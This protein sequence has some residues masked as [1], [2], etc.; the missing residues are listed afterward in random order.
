M[1]WLRRRRQG[2]A[3]VL[4]QAL[5]ALLT[6]LLVG[7]LTAQTLAAVA[8]K[9]ERRFM[10]GRKGEVVAWILAGPYATPQSDLEDPTTWQK[11][12]SAD[13]HR[14]RV[15]LGD[16][17]PLLIVPPP[18]GKGVFYCY[19][20][21]RAKYRQDAA[22]M[23]ASLQPFT[24]IAGGRKVKAT[25]SQ[26]AG[27]YRGLL[28]FDA[29]KNSTGILVRLT[30]QAG[31]RVVLVA[32]AKS[33]HARGAEYLR[34]ME[35]SL[36]AWVPSVAKPRSLTLE[37]DPPLPGVGLSR[38]TISWG[39]G[40]E[41]P[42]MGQALTLS[43]TGPQGLD[44][45][46]PVT[47]P[48]HTT[49]RL[50]S[51][52]DF[53]VDLP[54]TDRLGGEAPLVAVLRCGALDL[55]R[56]PV[57]TGVQAGRE[58][59]RLR[60]R[61]G[62]GEK[63]LK[64]DF[65]LSRF[66]LLKADELFQTLKQGNAYRVGSGDLARVLAQVK[67]WTEHYEA[68]GDPLAGRRGRIQG[69][70]I[71]R[72]DGSVQPYELYVPQRATDGPLPLVVLLHGYV[73]SYRRTDWMEIDP[74]MCRAL[75]EA[76][77]ALLLPF[78]RSNTD[79]LNVGERDVLDALEE[80]KR[81]YPIDEERTFLAGYSMGGSG[82][83]TLL[84]HYPGLFAAARVWSGRTDYYYWHDLN[85][86]ELPGYIR[87]AIDGDNPI[88]QAEDLLGTP[89]RVDHPLDDSLVKT[90]HTTAM[91]KRLR[92][93]G[94]KHL[95]V[96]QPQ[97]GGHWSFSTPLRRAETYRWFHQHRR[98]TSVE[99]LTVAAFNPYY[100]RNRWL[101]LWRV[102]RFGRRSLL[103]V[104]IG[105]GGTVQ[106]EGGENV[107]AFALARKALT[108]L[109]AKKALR[110][111]VGWSVVSSPTE[112]KDWV[113]VQRDG[114]ESRRIVK[115]GALAGPVKASMQEGFLLVLGTLGSEEEKL[116]N[117]RNLDRFVDEWFRFAKGEARVKQD[118]E[119]TTEDLARYHVICFGAPSTH[120][121]LQAVEG[122]VPFTL[123]RDVYGV[124][125]ERVPR[126]QGE[127]LGF[128]GCYPNPKN[129]S[130]LLVILDGL[131]YGDHLPIN[132]K[133]DL[134]PD[135]QIF[136]G[137]AGPRGTNQAVLAGY[138]DSD[139]QVDGRLLYSASKDGE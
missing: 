14:T 68:G 64:R 107:A 10:P 82:A 114:V 55:L 42:P 123:K 20:Q 102:Q 116:L 138:F 133:W 61:M 96:V 45:P 104:S 11:P 128:V 27:Q 48:S 7:P 19:T 110:L 49:S 122:E 130:R 2:S 74:S 81:R 23:A 109:S 41:L 18:S 63:R 135:F 57:M 62:K 26:A 36:P 125:E 34:G 127:A 115:H 33:L 88:D 50:R 22:V 15:H 93:L 100:G 47:V 70:Y 84:T 111:P 112:L 99:R 121:F 118:H 129:P 136:S 137:G 89:I 66:G 37:T 58:T 5:L 72:V 131:Y 31:Q 56:E 86:T 85:R 44:L 101:R 21:V 24:L 97:E 53:T 103:T 30:Y 12:I 65:P 78:G 73:P 16:G 98:D 54:A 51:G 77:M 52:I 25:P 75:E 119:L 87:F 92:A 4:R 35:V 9:G 120:G 6:G 91:A 105:K 95:T 76:G 46:D 80:V 59:T 132:H 43:I 83:W 90:G 108:G 13:R 113:L 69:A 134:V 32:G 8:G 39:A 3:A 29:G 117:R 124:G 60:E 94:H 17:S 139:W 40:T 67:G 106:V 71:S 28:P 79:F 1:P 38:F 126:R